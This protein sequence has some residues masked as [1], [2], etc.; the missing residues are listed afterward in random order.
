MSSSALYSWYLL[1]ILSFIVLPFANSRIISWTV[2]VNSPFRCQRQHLKLCLCLCLVVIKNLLRVRLLFRMPMKQAQKN[3][4]Y[5][6]RLLTS[7]KACTISA[8]EKCNKRICVVDW[9]KI[10]FLCCPTSII[11][12]N[13]EWIN[14]HFLEHCEN[15]K[16]Y[17]RQNTAQYIWILS[18]TV[19]A[20][21]RERTMNWRS[22]HIPMWY[23]FIRQTF[24]W[25]SKDLINVTIGCVIFTSDWQ[26][27]WK[28]LVLRDQFCS[29]M[30]L[31]NQEYFGLFLYSPQF[32]LPLGPGSQPF[33]M[34]T[35][36]FV[37][38]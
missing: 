12:F 34:I 4:S 19:R 8:K 3:D 14:I 27:H 22:F 10:K 35:S 2:K 16:L 32:V 28:L 23:F 31:R 5:Y 33:T 26:V 13:F 38:K 6:F 37:W 21:T 20:Q 17:L 7:V 29:T 30:K 1:V 18:S 15:F 25:K 11:D 24:N 36:D 9:K